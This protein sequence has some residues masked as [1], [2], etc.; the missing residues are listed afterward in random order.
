MS[1]VSRRQWLGSAATLGVGAALAGTATAQTRPSADELIRTVKGARMFDL[2]FTW[3]EQSP[4]L[5]LNPPYSFALNRNHKMTHEIFG[6]APG[7]RDSA[8]SR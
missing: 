1:D 7:S 5:S 6:Q 2:S 8:T 4:I 3:N